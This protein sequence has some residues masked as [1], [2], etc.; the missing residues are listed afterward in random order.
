[1]NKKSTILCC[2]LAL[3]ISICS[4]QTKIT[5]E[6][7]QVI[8]LDYP[9]LE[10]VKKNVETGSYEQAAQS[11]L[12]YYRDRNAKK[13]PDFSNGEAVVDLRQPLNQT[14]KNTADSALQ[15][16]FQPHKGYGFFD[17]GKDIN[18]QNWPVKDNEV[19]W[20]LH[21]V[22]WWQAMSL[23]YYITK[24]EAY[25]KEWILQF[26]DWVKKNPLGLSKD[27]DRFAWRPLEVSDRVQNLVPVF[28][29][30][31]KS[32]NFNAEFLME[33]LNSYHQQANYLPPN[34]AELGNHR[35]FE[36]QRVLFAGASFPEFKDAAS[37]RK[38]GIEVLNTEIKKQVYPDGVQFELS[39]VYHA[40]AIDIFLKAYRSAQKANVVNEF[41]A[42][43]KNTVENMILAFASILFPD[44]NTPMFGDSWIAEKRVRLRQ[45]NSWLE[46][47]PDNETIRYF[48]TDGKKGKAPDF[49]SK[50]LTT[51]GFYTFRNSWQDPATIMILKAS[52]PGEFHAQPDNGTFELWNNGRN[53]MPDAGVYVYSGDAEIMKQREWYRQTRLHNT[54]TL[55]NKNMVI[56]KAQLKKWKTSANLDQLTY[57]NPS[58]PDLDHQRTVFFID[59]KYFLIIDQAIGKASGKI[60]VHFHLKEDSKAFANA[61][62]NSI[63]T[64]YS[65]GNNLLIQYFGKDKAS[66]TPEASKVSYEYRK[67]ME[68]P[69]FVFEKDKNKEQMQT[70]V[71]IL[72]PFKGKKAPSIQVKENKGHDLANGSIDLTITTD[73]K[74][75]QIK[76][77]LN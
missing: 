70:F 60:G 59:K 58:Y 77:S 71:H 42:E 38:S 47:F 73:G 76:A 13:D 30:F 50:G 46:A 65:D 22:K 10:T 20:Q 24:N 68:R 11:L 28:D 48:A 6:S 69:A 62:Q 66:L 29:I 27:N 25:A 74:S 31:I 5:K 15:H 4:A 9:G 63:Q 67:E 57:V 49:L 43:Y 52:P 36:A 41:P 8:N 19:R 55:D 26:S 17:Y 44:Y 64:D 18:W 21:R 61:V 56:T 53:F 35:L 51:A 40:A 23:V 32:P 2:M 1:M 14:T 33:F 3:C 7:F 75:Q 37:W 72:Y 34:Y 12:T 45:F 54:L 16:R 39:P